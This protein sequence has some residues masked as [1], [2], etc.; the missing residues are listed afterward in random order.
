M[1]PTTLEAGRRWLMRPLEAALSLIGL[2]I[3]GRRSV[4][5]CSL[6]IRINWRLS[7]NRCRLFLLRYGW[8]GKKGLC[9]FKCNWAAG[10]ALTYRS[11]LPRLTGFRF[12][13]VRLRLAFAKATAR[14]A[15]NTVRLGSPRRRLPWA[16]FRW[17]RGPSRSAV[18]RAL[19]PLRTFRA[20]GRI[21]SVA[22]WPDASAFPW[23]WHAEATW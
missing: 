6:A 23:I 13:S 3:M 21:A 16:F 14:Q 11:P 9:R 5:S 4:S 7:S 12:P 22:F 17:L 10:N 18:K 2:Q 15:R 1:T 19:A 8:P 20:R